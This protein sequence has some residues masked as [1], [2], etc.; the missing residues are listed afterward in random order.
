MTAAVDVIIPFYFY[1]DWLFL[2]VSFDDTIGHQSNTKSTMSTENAKKQHE[3][4][5]NDDNDEN[6]DQLPNISCKFNRLSN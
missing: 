6:I 5:R 2:V 4:N 1:L 3:H